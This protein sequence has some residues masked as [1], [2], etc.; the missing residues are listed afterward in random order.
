MFEFLMMFGLTERPSWDYWWFV[1]LLETFNFTMHMQWLW[2]LSARFLA[3][4]GPCY[5]VW[6]WQTNCEAKDEGFP[7]C[8]I[9]NRIIACHIHRFLRHPPLGNK[10]E[11]RN[12]PGIRPYSSTISEIRK[13]TRNKAEI[14]LFQP[15]FRTNYVNS[16]I[17]QKRLISALFLDWGKFSLFP[18]RIC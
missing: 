12:R 2:A 13:I 16:E 11:I 1:F 5:H 18:V 6:G 9:I 15:Y 8:I 7:K 17:S 4:R 3:S 10:A 14:S